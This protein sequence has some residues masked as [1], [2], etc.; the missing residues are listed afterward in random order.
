MMIAENEH[1][2]LAASGAA[3]GLVVAFAGGLVIVALLVRSPAV[4]RLDHLRG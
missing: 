3:K 1:V 4:R 2:D